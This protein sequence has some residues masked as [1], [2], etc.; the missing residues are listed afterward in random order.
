MDKK[1]KKRFTLL[2][3]AGMLLARGVPAVPTQSNV[4]DRVD[5]ALQGAREELRLSIDDIDALASL[6]AD[7]ATVGMY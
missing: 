2:A 5:G 3:A 6:D 1:T 4:G 7:E